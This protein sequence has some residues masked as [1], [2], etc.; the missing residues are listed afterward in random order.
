MRQSVRGKGFRSHLDKTDKG[1]SEVGEISPATI[2]NRTGRHHDTAQTADD[3]DGLLNAS[4]P[5]DDILGDK[6]ALAGMHL[7]T[8]HDES[9]VAVLLDE[10]VAGAEMAGDF[11]ADDDATHGGR[12]NRREPAVRLGVKRPEFRGQ[13]P[14]DLRGHRGILQEQGAL[15]ELPAVEPGAED[16][17]AVQKGS[18]SF[19]EIEDVGHGNRDSG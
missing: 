5:G 14:A 15:E 2:D 4:A 12:D 17:V 6:E 18:G 10:D 3:V 13:F 9:A 19:E 1:T 11:L 8:A 7:E 16:E